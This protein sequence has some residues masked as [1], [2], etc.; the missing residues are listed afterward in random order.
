MVHR[1][2]N[3]AGTYMG[4]NG[5]LGHRRLSI[6]DLE[7]GDQPITDESGKRA[8]VANG[9]IYNFESLRRWLSKTHRFKTR[10]DTEA[11]LHLYDA[12]GKDAAGRLDGMF[13]VAITDGPELF[14]VRDPMGIK[15]LYYAQRDGM[16]LFA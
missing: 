4:A 12:L 5:V 8:I 14:L 10:S 13:A 15:P 3:G 11:A 6:V 9:E 7:R 1:G 16:L 2:P